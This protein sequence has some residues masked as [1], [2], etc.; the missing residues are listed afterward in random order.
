M[1]IHVCVCLTYALMH[2]LC[3]RV[4]VLI[5]VVACVRE[6]DKCLCVCACWCACVR[7]SVFTSI[8]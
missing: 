8:L 2:I 1:F 4:W 5:C 3:A 7:S 6:T